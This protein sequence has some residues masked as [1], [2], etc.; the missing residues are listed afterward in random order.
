MKPITKALAIIALLYN[1]YIAK[2]QDTFMDVKPLVEQ[3]KGYLDVTG[4]IKERYRN[5]H[6]T[7]ID[8]LGVLHY[9][10]KYDLGGEV[11]FEQ[12]NFTGEA[13]PS[14]NGI[15]VI[16]DGY[17]TFYRFRDQWWFDFLK[18]GIDGDEL[19]VPAPPK[20]EPNAPLEKRIERDYT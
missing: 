11:F 18:N 15:S 10:R 7:F 19:H 16:L 3:V 14:E 8:A 2:A 17:P 6:Y 4:S 20:I 5:L 1:P 12:Y 9:N 13:L